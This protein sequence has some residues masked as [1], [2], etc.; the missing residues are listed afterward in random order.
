MDRFAWSLKPFSWNAAE[1]IAQEL[2]MPL[3]AGIILARRGYTDVEDVRRFLDVAGEVPDPYLFSDM[4]LAVDA[5]LDAAERGRRIVVHGDYD[6]DGISATALLIRGLAD[7]GVPAEHYLP[8]RFVQGYGLSEIGV[9][10]IAAGGDALLVTV[11]CGVN[12][13]QEV[14]LARSLGLDVIVTDHHQA[15][16]ELPDC[17]VI[18]PVRGDY[19]HGD[20]CGVGVAFKL[21]HAL[22]LRAGEGRPD[23]VPEALR[24]HLDLVALGTVAD[25]VPLRGENRHY[26]AEGVVRLAASGKVGLRSLLSLS[27]GEGRVDAQTIG[28][29]LAPRLNAAGRLK[30]P[31]IPL[32]LLLTDDTDEAESLARELDALNRERRNIEAGV[33]SEALAVVEAIAELPPLLVVSGRGWHEGVLGIVASR[34]VERY[35]RPTVML[36]LNEGVAR[37]SARSIAA[38]DIMA[39][40]NACERHLTVFGGHKQAAGLTMP[41]SA[42]ADFTGDLVAHAGEM[43]TEEDL[44]P[45]YHPDAVV[46]GTDLNLET[47]DALARLAPFGM[48]NPR[49]KLMAL[50]ARFEDPRVT[51]KGDHLQCTVVVDD[52]R[53]RG[54]GFGLAP[55]LP[56]LVENGLRGHAGIRLEAS[57]WQGT[58]RAEVHLHSLYRSSD[59]G[60]SALGCSPTC[61]H[62]DDL[63]MLPPCPRCEE[64]FADAKPVDFEAR[65]LRDIPGTLTLVAE[66]LSSGEPTAIVGTQV[67]RHLVR[68]GCGLPLTEL[69]VGGVDCVSRHCWRT[70]VDGLRPDALLYIDWDAAERRPALLTSRS[71]VIVADPLYKPGHSHVLRLAADAG[72]RIHLVYGDAERQ[73]TQREL[74]VRLHPRPWMVALYRAFNNGCTDT[75]DAFRKVIDTSWENTGLMPTT[76]ELRRAMQLLEAIGHASDEGQ[77]ATMM[78]SEHPDYTAAEA[79]FERAVRQCRKT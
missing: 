11:D 70:R 41:E 72:A 14:T 73:E 3:I 17:P 71:H 32:R 56:E 10:E 58:S 67:N 79:D 55:E 39:G 18:H 30:D 60:E 75:D 29:R 36:S 6:V 27:Q 77:K 62:M 1:R 42:L 37:G 43:L 46:G 38:Y 8:S 78:A 33:L 35:H 12:Y 23:R 28:Y 52:V 47:I 16:E 69:G 31:Q 53:A 7:L 20:L 26:V 64:P 19:P 66:I 57:E 48:G 21:L 34:I 40:L 22:H 24:V 9:R 59:L 13:P 4:D 51:R 61:P 50:D 74:A 65:D 63:D 49:V 54:I 45:T 44:T 2:D 25:L 15:G 5:L 68:F 76:D